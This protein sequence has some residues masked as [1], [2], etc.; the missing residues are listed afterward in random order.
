MGK[1]I[2][3]DE[4]S[5]KAVF[6]K[7]CAVLAVFVVGVWCVLLPVLMSVVGLTDD[8]IAKGLLMA[9]A[10]V[11]GSALTLAIFAVFLHIRK[12]RNQIYREELENQMLAEKS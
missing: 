12:N 10:I 7:D 2:V 4:K 9:A 3:I 6:H 8:P 11:G 5:M 1:E